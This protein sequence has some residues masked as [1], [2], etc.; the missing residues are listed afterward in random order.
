MENMQLRQILADNLREAMEQTPGI[1]TQIALARRAGIA[2]SHLSKILRGEASATTDLLNALANAMGREP[3]ELLAD[4]NE[5]REA[6]I[7][8]ML[9]GASPDYSKAVAQKRRKR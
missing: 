2:Q 6:A 4:S 7:R 1:D 5:T 8:K 9:V 3:W